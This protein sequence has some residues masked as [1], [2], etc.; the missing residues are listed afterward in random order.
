MALQRADV[1]GTRV[2]QDYDDIRDPVLAGAPSWTR[3]KLRCCCTAKF[4]SQMWRV[5]EA[6]RCVSRA[7]GTVSVTDGEHPIRT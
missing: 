4:V 7:E 5:P 3:S 6:T 1:H 2:G